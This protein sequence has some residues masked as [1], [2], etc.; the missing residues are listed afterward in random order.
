MAE[1]IDNLLK[2]VVA[3]G[4]LFIPDL[5]RVWWSTTPDWCDRLDSHATAK[6]IYTVYTNN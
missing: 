1:V 6:T 5:I 3:G 2:V 4:V